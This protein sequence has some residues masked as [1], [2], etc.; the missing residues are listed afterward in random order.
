MTCNMLDDFDSTAMGM[1][2]RVPLDRDERMCS[3]CSIPPIVAS[4]QPGNDG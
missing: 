4:S 2:G 1:T 3:M